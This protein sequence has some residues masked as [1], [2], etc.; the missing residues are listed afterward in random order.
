M[1]LGS[2]SNFS[3]FDSYRFLASNQYYATDKTRRLQAIGY[4]I[5]EKP[6]VYITAVNRVNV[7]NIED[8]MG[9]SFIYLNK[10]EKIL[11][12]AIGRLVNWRQ[13]GGLPGNATKETGSRK[14]G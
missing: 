12:G 13:N 5:F 1:A 11:S 9:Y 7:E 6:V 4:D 10:V 8:A 2:C 14:R 3:E